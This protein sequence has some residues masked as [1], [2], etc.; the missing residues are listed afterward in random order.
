MNQRQ[1]EVFHAIML[2]RTASRA[3]EVLFM[4]QPAVSKTLQQLERSIG[5]ALFDRIKGRL[6]PTPEGQLFHAEVAR[7]FIGM[8]QLSQ[9]AARIRDF[10]SGKLRIAS[11]SALSTSIVPRALKGFQGHHPDVAITYQ[12]RLSS[13]VRD[14]VASGRFDL[15]IA[16]DEVDTAGVD[17]EPFCRYKAVIA[18]PPGHP[19]AKRPQVRPGDLHGASFIA[20]SPDDT[21]RREADALF[22]AGGVEPRIVLETPFSSNVCAMALAGLGCGLVNPVTAENY[23][24]RGLILR[25]FDAEVHFRYLMLFPSSQRQSRIVR[26]CVLEFRKAVREFGVREFGV[27][28]LP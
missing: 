2:H 17:A 16:A 12:T 20:L 9:T 22:K 5:F 28:P 21:A 14:L 23:V 18:L 19:L 25:P 26:D 4:S 13:E 8:I 15:G 10:G 7:S 24:A 3:A 11:L 27:C 6:V 1:I